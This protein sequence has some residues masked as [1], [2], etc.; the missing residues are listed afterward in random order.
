MIYSSLTHSLITPRQAVKAAHDALRQT[1]RA[2]KLYTTLQDGRVFGDM[3]LEP[4]FE[5]SLAFSHVL[6]PMGGKK[7]YGP[8]SDGACFISIGLPRARSSCSSWL[9]V[10]Q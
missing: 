8:S 3:D 6:A 1:L 5:P 4:M 7:L 2:S 9:I 10:A